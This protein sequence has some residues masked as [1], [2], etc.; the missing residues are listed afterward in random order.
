MAIFLQ[1]KIMDNIL[2]SNIQKVILADT[3]VPFVNA[4]A[5]PDC[6]TPYKRVAIGFFSKN[7]NGFLGSILCSS[8]LFVAAACLF[9]SCLI[10]KPGNYFKN[11]TRDTTIYNTSN[12]P[13]ELQIK[14]KDILSISI[15]SINKMEDEL[16]NTPSSSGKGT[17]AGFQ[18]TDDGYIHM[19]KLGKV[20]VAGLTRKQLKAMLE[21]DLEP[22]LKEPIVE[23]GFNNHFITVLGEIGKQ[24]IMPIPEE[25]I[26]IVDVLAQSGSISPVTKL[27]HVM[28]I[29]EKDDSKEFRHVNLEDHSIFTSP[30]YYLQPNDVL[31]L[32]QDEKI[33]KEQ[34]RRDRY[35][36]YSSVF[37]QT[38]SLAIII[39]QVFFR[40]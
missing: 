9:S 36:Q 25:H 27:S 35:Q 5:L 1:K 16:Y 29:R 6:N 14:K 34:F 33:V 18:V 40:K 30:Y 28:I 19:H 11:I 37:F 4:A 2:N 7:G 31:V 20:K 32:N 12:I 8:F 24:Q 39:Y 22:Y 10:S 13:A 23:I 21:K 38:L 17:A 15:S 3:K 26:S